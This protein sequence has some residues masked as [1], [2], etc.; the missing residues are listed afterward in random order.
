LSILSI[1][2]ALQ[3]A[4]ELNSLSKS[5]NMAGWRVGMLAAAEERINEIICFKSNMDSGMFMPIQLAAIEA[6]QLGK[7]WFNAL[8]NIYFNRRKLAFKLLDILN[9]TY[10][11]NQVGLFVWAKIPPN[12]SDGYFFSDFI[13]Q[14]Y[15]IFITPGGIF[16]DNGNYYI[17]VSLCCTEENFNEAINRIKL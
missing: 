14:N 5:H 12:Y 15:R 2:N 16:G 1:P 10:S 11:S 3:V 8:N 9:C 6:L 17:R 7:N 13:L 4:I